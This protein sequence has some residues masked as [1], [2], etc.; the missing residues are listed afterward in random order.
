MLARSSRV[1]VDAVPF[2]IDGEPVVKRIEGAVE[3][4]GRLRGTELSRK[5]VRSALH[6]RRKEGIAV[7][8][9]IVRRPKGLDG[10]IAVALGVVEDKAAARSQKPFHRENIAALPL[11]PVIEEGKFFARIAHKAQFEPLGVA[12][13]QREGEVSVQCEVGRIGAA[14]AA[15]AL[16][17]DPFAAVVALGSAACLQHSRDVG[18]I[19]VIGAEAVRRDAAEIG[20]RVIVQLKVQPLPHPLLRDAVEVLR[21]PQTCVG[22][23]KGIVLEHGDRLL[24]AAQQEIDVV[25]TAAAQLE[26]DIPAAGSRKFRRAQNARLS[27]AGEP[28]RHAETVQKIPAVLSDGRRRRIEV[29]KIS[30]FIADAK[31]FVPLPAGQG[32]VLE[33][34]VGKVVRRRGRNAQPQPDAPLL[35][36]E[37]DADFPLRK[38]GQADAV[39]ENREVTSLRIGAAARPFGKI[40]GKED[41][42]RVADGERLIVVQIDRDALA[43]RRTARGKDGARRAQRCRDPE[44]DHRFFHL[45]SPL[46]FVRFV[47]DGRRSQK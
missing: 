30:H 5:I 10:K 16:V 9:K 21:Q 1:L 3:G 40:V 33:P 20:R 42:V 47:T 41:V 43:L 14:G 17:D 12:A 39:L 35:I 4:N 29:V 28:I 44:H 15:A 38:T 36:P 7:I 45:F 31:D 13:L 19:L 18:R 22:I 26:G 2:E 6:E 23:G 37:R 24:P 25:R 27:L 34:A 8:G 46:L 11:A 32:P